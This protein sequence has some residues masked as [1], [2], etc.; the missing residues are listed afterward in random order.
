MARSIAPPVWRHE[1]LVV[2]NPEPES[3]V[4]KRDRF[5]LPATVWGLIATVVVA[6]IGYGIEVAAGNEVG[7]TTQGTYGVVPAIVGIVV[8]TLVAMIIGLFARRSTEPYDSD[9]PHD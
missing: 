1:Y 2:P 6:A 9:R 3:S 8:G 7:S 4:D 5:A